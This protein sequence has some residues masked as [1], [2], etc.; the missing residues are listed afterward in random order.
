MPSSG[1]LALGPAYRNPILSKWI[2]NDDNDS[3][4]TVENRCA[5]PI[6]VTPS[7]SD[8]SQD[9]VYGFTVPALMRHT[10]PI[11]PD[12]G[13]QLSQMQ[14]TPTNGN[15]APASVG[16]MVTGLPFGLASVSNA[17]GNIAGRY[18]GLNNV[19]YLLHS[20]GGAPS[21]E[22]Y[23]VESLICSAQSV[24]V[25][26][27]QVFTHWVGYNAIGSASTNLDVV[28]PVDMCLIAQTF[29]IEALA[30][31]GTGPAT[32]VVQYIYDRNA[33]FPTPQL[34]G[35]AL[36]WITGQPI[37]TETTILARGAVGYALGI[38]GGGAGS[39]TITVNVVDWVGSPGA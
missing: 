32:L 16:N 14:A 10:V 8:G 33:P 34:E 30:I 31:T 12:R 25:T 37:G 24:I 3:W 2:A 1:V 22:I 27:S 18:C 19:P 9:L 38:A 21:E 17:S 6:D 5:L 4:I 28:G 15:T 23:P 35:G 29:Q 20:A 13:V 7:F 26:A 36:A 11:L 39:D